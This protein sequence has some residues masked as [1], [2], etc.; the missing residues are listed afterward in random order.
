MLCDFLVMADAL[1]RETIE[2]KRHTRL[3]V[4]ALTGRDP[5][6]LIEL[7][8]DFEELADIPKTPKVEQMF[9]AKKVWQ[10]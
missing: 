4:G 6:H 5:R 2:K 1:Y 9:R 7:P 8:G 3:I 10:Q